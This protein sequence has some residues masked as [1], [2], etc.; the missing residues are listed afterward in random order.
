M[1]QHTDTV[2]CKFKPVRPKHVLARPATQFSK[3]KNGSKE[4]KGP[5]T[6]KI[7]LPSTRAHATVSVPTDQSRRCFAKS[8]AARTAALRAEK[9]ERQE[10]RARASGRA[11][12]D[13]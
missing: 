13:T 4:S 5:A 8:S 10:R 6:K 11:V 9:R 3:T 1:E 12:A 7:Q 2:T